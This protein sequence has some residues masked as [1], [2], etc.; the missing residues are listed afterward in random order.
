MHSSHY[1]VRNYDEFDDSQLFLL[2]FYPYLNG[3]LKPHQLEVTKVLTYLAQA[4]HELV[5]PEVIQSSLL[6]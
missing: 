3:Y 5:P 2:N 4:C 1:C 6:V